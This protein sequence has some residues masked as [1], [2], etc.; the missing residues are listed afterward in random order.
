MIF[1]RPRSSSN[2]VKD[3]K[4]YSSAPPTP[5]NTPPCKSVSGLVIWC[6]SVPT[7][8]CAPQDFVPWESTCKSPFL[9]GLLLSS[10][11]VST[12]WRSAG[13]RKARS[14]IYSLL[15]PPAGLLVAVGER[16]QLLPVALSRIGLPHSRGYWQLLFSLAPASL[17]VA[18]TSTI[19]IVGMI[20]LC[21]CSKAL[22]IPFINALLI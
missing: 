15:F 10:S 21:Y 22:L 12:S 19:P 17:D 13:R 16:P 2:P 11:K 14:W 8:H 1:L 5:S 20:F 3:F 18:V 9:S 7:L 6:F 4:N